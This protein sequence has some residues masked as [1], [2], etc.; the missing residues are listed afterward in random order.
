MTIGRRSALPIEPRSAFQPNGSADCPAAIT[1]VAPAASATRTMA[2]RLPGSWTSHATTT[3]G[4]RSPRREIACP[5]GARPVGASATMRAGRATGLTRRHDG[6]GGRRRPRRRRPRA[7]ATSG[8]MSRAARGASAATIAMSIAS[9]APSASVDQVRAVEQ[10]G[11]GRVAAARRARKRATTGFCRLRDHGSASLAKHSTVVPCI[12]PHG[13]VDEGAA[14]QEV[15]GRDPRARSRAEARAAEG[16]Q[17]RAR[18]GRPARERRVQA[19]KER[20]RLVE[21]RISMLQKRVAEIALHQ[22]RPDSDRSRRLRLDAARHREAP[23]RSW[24]SSS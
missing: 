18:A 13:G 20:Q 15:R 12:R 4:A 17:A 10:H 7:G 16:D 3:S 11:V 6:R 1:P 5:V 21:A 19:A 14:D 8:A 22:R 9:P 2:P 24:S 23:A